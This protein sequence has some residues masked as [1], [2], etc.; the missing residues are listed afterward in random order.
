[1]N[2][3]AIAKKHSDFVLVVIILIAVSLVFHWIPV[4]LAF[5]NFF[6]LPVLAAA[7]LMG[8]RV[9]ILSSVLC[10]LLV[11]LYYFW[12]WTEGALAANLGVA[13]LRGII[14][15]NWVTLVHVT[16]WGGF[17][18]LTGGLLGRIHEAEAMKKQA[19]VVQ[20]RN[21]LIEQLKQK[22]EQTL[23]STMDPTV[24]RLTMQGR[25]RQEKRNVSVMF[26][27]L[28]GFTAYA[29]GRPPEVVLEDLNSFYAVMGDIIESYHGHIDKYLGDGIMAEFGA[30]LD[31]EQHCLQAVVAALKMQEKFRTQ[32]MPWH[33][34]I[35]VASGEA[36]VGLMG[37]RRRS[38]S[39][40]GNTVNLAKRLEELCEPGHVY[41]D[42]A[43]YLGAQPTLE[44][45][46]IRSLSGSRARDSQTREA[47]AEKEQ[48]LAG[49][50]DNPE[51]LFHMGQLYF[52]DQ[53]ASKALEYFRRAMELDPENQEIKV[54]YADATVK[55][56][57]YEKIGI[58]GITEKLA[59]F[60]PSGLVKPMLDRNRFPK[61]FYD[62]FHPVEEMLEIPDSVTLPVEVL[63][64]SVGHSL[65][66]AV[67][68]Y[69]LA[70]QL[71]LSEE[72][73]RDLLIAARLQDLGK[74]IVWHHLLSR[75]G[76]LSDEERRDLEAHVAESVAVAM[77]AGYDRPG[78]LDIIANHHELL[79]GA[80]YP[81]RAK[82][83]DI[84]IGARITG[85]ADVYCALTAW[86]PYRDAW[87]SRVALSELRKGLDAGSYDPKVFEA[88][89]GLIIP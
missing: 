72:I 32:S 67:L 24:A 8:T 53:E 30:P 14:E 12:F 43:S 88:L 87:D 74:S 22:M 64:A 54:A 1:M 4:K 3:S 76:G 80:G 84:P 27:D 39:A 83:D 59:V 5:L 66:V 41:I 63:D 38:Y 85:V 18:I 86:R 48:Q 79:N 25:L 23:Y 9:A 61:K 21:V 51:L 7:Y 65:S 68:S 26:C 35:G 60:E 19:E 78:V 71:G 44:G 50:P 17:L 69:A 16:M 28:K 46:Q 62:R 45:R 10:V 47:I 6:Y 57:E 81:R 52:W 70:E 37:S 77:R 29:K 42:E 89:N 55:K 40:I 75:R 73:K 49:D 31:Y 58:R 36:L 2:F 56:D 82:G 15:Q 13:Q 20:E 33:L 11:L 34:R